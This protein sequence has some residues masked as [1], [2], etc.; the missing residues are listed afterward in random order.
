[1]LD[2]LTIPK[3]LI[4]RKYHNIYMAINQEK[5]SEFLNGAAR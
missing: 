5:N 4:H 3:S 1:M 2:L